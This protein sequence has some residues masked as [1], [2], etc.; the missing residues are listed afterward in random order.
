MIAVEK[1]LVICEKHYNSHFME[2][3]DCP[4]CQVEMLKS[5]IA[6]LR[7]VALALREWIDAVPDSTPLPTM[8]GI[9]RDWVDEV[10]TRMEGE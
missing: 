3:T 10:L 1:D 8:P 6:E 2:F 7:E 9:D 4:Y 5:Q